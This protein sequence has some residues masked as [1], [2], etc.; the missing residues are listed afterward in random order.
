MVNIELF[1]KNLQ[2]LDI[3][4]SI[5]FYLLKG[6]ISLLTYAYNKG[7]SLFT[8]KH[9]LAAITVIK[10]QIRS[11]LK[12][13]NI[14]VSIVFFC[15]YGLMM[16]INRDSLPLLIAYSGM[17]LVAVVVFII[18]FIFETKEEDD[19][20]V[21]RSKKRTRKA[22]KQVCKVIKYVC[23][24]FAI[25]FTVAMMFIT[26]DFNVA[27]IAGVIASS[28]FLVIQ[29]IFNIIGVLFDRYIEMLRLGFKLDVDNSDIVKMV[30]PLGE[31]DRRVQRE[32]DEMEGNSEFTDAEQE[33]V[34]E[35]TYVAHNQ[36]EKKKKSLRER[37]EKN[38]EKLKE[39]KKKGR[40]N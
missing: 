38:L 9:S 35:L 25:G 39:A 12:A 30:D 11:W 29:I 1:P 19:K 40:N 32:V 20:E 24:F 31:K 28:T 36:E 7:M 23:N 6:I 14:I 15:F 33:I 10:R 4:L 2:K 21:K 26:S 34:D 8:V 22:I 17:L 5:Y 3:F 18:G 13:I 16:F 27:S 37:L